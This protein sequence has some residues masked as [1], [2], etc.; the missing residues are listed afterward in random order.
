MTS[1]RRA[2]IVSCLLA[3]AL[4]PV[5]ESQESAEERAMGLWAHESKFPVGL[6]GELTVTRRDGSW[7]G[8]I[9]G[10]TAEALGER[11][12]SAHRVSG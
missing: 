3:L 6:A 4:P 5:A 11:K 1:H 12:R 7:Q 8:S 2:A 9:A 10:A